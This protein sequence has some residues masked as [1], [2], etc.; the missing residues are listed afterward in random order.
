MAVASTVRRRTPARAVA[1]AEALLAA[2]IWAS[3]FVGVKAALEHAGPLT[4][5]GLRYTLAF[6]LFVPLLRRSR[7][8]L[9]AGAWPRLALIGISQYTVG[10]GAL[11]W[12]LRTLSATAGSLSLSLVPIVVLLLQI[13]WLRERPRGVAL[14]GLALTVGGSVLFFLPTFEAGD[15]A[16]LGALAVAVLAF[17]VLP[18]VGRELA[19][20][21]SVGTVPLTAIP[22]GIGGGV[23]LAAALTWEGVPELP[24]AM[25][26]VIVGLAVVNTALAYLVY[27]HALRHL[28]AVEANVILNLSPLGTALLAWLALGE[29]LSPLRIVAMLVV[30]LGAG[31]VQVRRGGGGG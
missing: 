30:L 10:N 17:A 11:F 7:G 16:A 26:G 18:V 9:P 29:T 25:W 23:L 20:A 12:S 24:L 4:V 5:A 3:S 13:V 27:N 22:L 31:L 2:G 14:L 6:L 21:G 8:A 28:T 19:R 15:A 1:G